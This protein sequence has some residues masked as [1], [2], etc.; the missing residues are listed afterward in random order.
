MNRSG[1]VCATATSPSSAEAVSAKARCIGIP[2][3]FT[4][5]SSRGAKRECSAAASSSNGRTASTL[6]REKN[7]TLTNSRT[8]TPSFALAISGPRSGISLPLSTLPGSKWPPT[9]LHAKPN[10]T[11]PRRMPFPASQRGARTPY[12]AFLE[13]GTISVYPGAGPRKTL[14]RTWAPAAA[15]F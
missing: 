15:R 4:A 3:M 14:A 9:S 8:V 2:S 5:P 7:S 6:C 1:K 12:S 13:A 11:A 10:P